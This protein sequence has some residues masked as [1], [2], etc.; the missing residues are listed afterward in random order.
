VAALTARIAAL[1]A[2]ERFEDA[3]AQRDRLTAF[4]RAAARLQRL[5]ALTDVR[6]W[7]RPG[8]PAT[9]GG[10]S[11]SCAVVA[12]SPPAPSPRGAH[13]APYVDALLATA[14][15]VVTGPGPLPSATAEEVECVLRWLETSG[16]RL[17]RLRGT[18][19]SPAQGAGGH[20]GW[21]EA[22]PDARDAVRPFDDRRAL[23]PV[24][25]PARACRL[26]GPR[27][28][29]DRTAAGVWGRRSGGQVRPVI[30]AIVMVSAAVDQI[31]EVAQRIAELDSVS[32]V[33]SV[34]GDVDLVAMVRVRRHDELHDVIAGRLNKVEGVLATSTHIAFQ[35]YSR[36]DLE[37]TFSL[38]STT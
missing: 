12:S 19:A 7:S 5:R 28:D 36:H 3:A 2:D 14:E 26:S 33:Y 22:A 20:R 34:A 17:V 9:S 31:P 23:R 27:R 4:V 25:R 30:T 11:R 15:T 32:E 8:R 35:A 38:G 10:R 6:S 16:T 18:F 37:A 21:L 24:A 13:P 1:A 29:A